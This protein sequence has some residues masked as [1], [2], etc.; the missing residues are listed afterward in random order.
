VVTVTDKI[1]QR[2][3]ANNFMIMFYI[4]GSLVYSLI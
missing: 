4:L 3:S 2:N 1:K